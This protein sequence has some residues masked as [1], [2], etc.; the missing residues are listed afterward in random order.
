MLSRQNRVEAF[1][2]QPLAYPRDRGEAGVQRFH[3]AAVAPALTGL[4]D[5]RLEQHASLED[6]GRGM[7]A[8]ADQIFQRRPFVLAQTNNVLLDCGFRHVPI[9]GTIDDAARESENQLRINDGRH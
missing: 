7:L 6:R 9:P 4:G 5:I 8:L 2:D 1:L 3:D